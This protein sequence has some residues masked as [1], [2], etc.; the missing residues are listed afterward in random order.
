[1]TTTPN[2][3]R[4]DRSDT[5]ADGA[6]HDHAEKMIVNRRRAIAASMRRAGA[7]WQ[8]IADTAVFP[9]TGQPCYRPGTSRTVPYIDVKR[10]LEEATRDMA[11]EVSEMRELESQRL[12]D[13]LLRLRPGIMLGDPKSINSAIRITEVRARL[14]GLNE[15]ERHEVI[16]V[17]AL[18][19]A[20]RELEQEIAR[21]AASDARTG[22]PPEGP[23]RP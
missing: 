9:D 13:L 21:R 23:A 10:G 15:P 1:M 7:T 3:H 14:Y 5:M 20:A 16:T 22:Q 8:Q 18:D 4:G 17:D 19:A 11:L 12:D 6:R 2:G